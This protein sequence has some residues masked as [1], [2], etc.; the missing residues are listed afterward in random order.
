MLAKYHPDKDM[1]DWEAT[2]QSQTINE[3]SDDIEYIIT[4][5]IKEMKQ[6]GT[7]ISIPDCSITLKI[8]TKN[9]RQKRLEINKRI[10]IANIAETLIFKG[11]CPWI[12]NTAPDAKRENE[13]NELKKTP[14]YDKIEKF[15][16]LTKSQQL[17][18]IGKLHKQLYNEL[19]KKGDSEK[20]LTEKQANLEQINKEYD[21]VNKKI[22]QIQAKVET[23]S[24]RIN[25]VNRMNHEFI[26]NKGT[27]KLTEPQK[28]QYGR[29]GQL[30]PPEPNT[31]EQ[32]LHK[33]E[34]GEITQK[35][36]QTLNKWQIYKC[37]K[38]EKSNDEWLTM[39]RSEAFLTV[40]QALL[41]KEV[42]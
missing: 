5:W 13:I 12:L 38:G 17:D 42:E 35:E 3:L 18:E 30:Q 33:A 14:I 9:R 1:D 26:A 41:E 29:D 6:F 19:K 27:S 39:P 20:K 7:Q 2:K 23:I 28:I 36:V 10:W 31:V 32:I 40:L 37:Y 11:S 15:L 24:E 25:M 34:I 8:P 21:N 22:K 4:K 16:K